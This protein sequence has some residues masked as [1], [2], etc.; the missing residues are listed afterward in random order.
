MNDPNS[1]TTAPGDDYFIGAIIDHYRTKSPV[2]S[3]TAYTWIGAI[4]ARLRDSEEE[5]GA[6][7][8]EVRRVRAER[9]ALLAAAG[10][11]LPDIALAQVAADRD[12]WREQAYREAAKADGFRVELGQIG[13]DDSDAA[14]IEDELGRKL[15]DRVGDILAA[16][17]AADGHRLS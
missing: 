4:L 1:I 6:A 5:R 16:V 12:R 2:S 13:A 15:L 10:G 17:E 3:D 14:A 11:R 9:D 8:D 7:E